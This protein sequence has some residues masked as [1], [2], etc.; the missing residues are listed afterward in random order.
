MVFGSFNT[1]LAAGA[2]QK[3]TSTS[4][5]TENSSKTG[6]SFALE[7]LVDSNGYLTDEGLEKLL[8]LPYDEEKY[9]DVIENDDGTRTL[10]LYTSPIKFKNEKGDME[11]IDNNIV[12]VADCNTFRIKLWILRLITNRKIFLQS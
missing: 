2:E 9:Y 12:I 10:K 7:E 5:N 6:Q 3:T 8:S 11:S 4:K 1:A